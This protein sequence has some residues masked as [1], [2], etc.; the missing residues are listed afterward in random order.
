[1]W[2]IDD[3]RF[4]NYRLNLINSVSVVQCSSVCIE[5]FSR[6]AVNVYHNNVYHNNSIVISWLLNGNKIKRTLW[7]LCPF[8]W[9]CRQGPIVLCITLKPWHYNTNRQVACNHGNII[10]Q[11]VC[12]HS[13]MTDKLPLKS[14]MLNQLYQIRLWSNKTFVDKIYIIIIN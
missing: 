1:M 14:F 10:R 5:W 12:N 11:I 9:N 6:V 4:C 13:K 7:L 8:K 3:A 2:V